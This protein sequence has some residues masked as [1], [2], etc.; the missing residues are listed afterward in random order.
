MHTVF[1]PGF[2]GL[3]EAIYIQE[4]LIEMLMPAVYKSFVR[5]FPSNLSSNQCY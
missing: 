4:R 5:D 1:Q 3:L 2:P